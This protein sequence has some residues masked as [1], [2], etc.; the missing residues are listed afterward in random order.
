MDPFCSA[1]EIFLATVA[2]IM[3]PPH[4]PQAMSSMTMQMFGYVAFTFVTKIFLSRL[5]ESTRRKPGLIEMNQIHT[6][7]VH[8]QLAF[9]RDSVVLMLDFFFFSRKSFCSFSDIHIFNCF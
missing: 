8:S 3:F 2:Q 1:R 6:I 9:L 7:R 4:H 5:R